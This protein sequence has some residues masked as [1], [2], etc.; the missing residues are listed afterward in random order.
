MYCA[1][2]RAFAH[3][4]RKSEVP[5][6]VFFL[7]FAGTPIKNIGPSLLCIYLYLIT[8]NADYIAGQYLT[9]FLKMFGGV[10]VTPTYVRKL[11]ESDV[12]THGTEEERKLY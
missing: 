9:Y 2:M 8:L 10:H 4:R 12:A 3:N 11:L 5:T 1:Y 7:S 6:E